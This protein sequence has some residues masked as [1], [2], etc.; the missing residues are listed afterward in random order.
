M[1]LQNRHACGDWPDLCIARHVL[2]HMLDKGEHYVADGGYRSSIDCRAMTPTGR[3]DYHDRQVAVARTRH[4]TVNRRFKTFGV[5][6][7]RFRHPLEK[8]GI[9]LKSIANIVQLTIS[10]VN[11]FFRLMSKLSKQMFESR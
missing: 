10:K 11:I 3:N 4:E 9:V 6:C 8:H 2:H 1:S 5:I 7:Q